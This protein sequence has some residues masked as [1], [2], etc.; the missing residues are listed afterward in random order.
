METGLGIDLDPI[1]VAGADSVVIPDGRGSNVDFEDIPPLVEEW[2]TSLFRSCG[3]MIMSNTVR[4]E[5]MQPSN[6][7]S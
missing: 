5:C 2:S 6:F 4:R 1:D 3:S 7:Q